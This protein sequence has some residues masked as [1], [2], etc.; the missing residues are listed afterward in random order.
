MALV[1]SASLFFA[2]SHHDT[3]TPAPPNCH[4]QLD[5][6]SRAALTAATRRA[7]GLPRPTYLA[8]LSLPTPL[9]LHARRA[10]PFFL[11]HNPRGRPKSPKGQEATAD[12][13]ADDTSTRAA[14]D[15]NFSTI[16]ESQFTLWV[17]A[18]PGHAEARDSRGNTPLWAAARR[19]NYTL[20]SYL[21]VLRGV[22]VNG[23]T[24]NGST[25]IYHA[26]NEEVLGFLLDRGAE[27]VVWNDKGWLPL[28]H[29][30][31]AGR[32]DCV[33]RLLEDPRGRASI[34]TVVRGED[35]EG[36]SA[37]HLACWHNN[38]TPTA[39]LAI[40]RHLLEAGA[41]PTLPNRHGRN[42]LQVLQERPSVEPLELALIEEAMDGQRAASLIK[43]R[44]VVVGA[45]R[46]EA[47]QCIKRARLGRGEGLPSIELDTE[48]EEGDNFGSLM[49]FLM[50]LQSK[51][52]TSGMPQGVFVG[53]MSMIIPPWHALR[54]GIKGDE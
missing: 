28:M 35:F 29:H 4:A 27:P 6:P 30:V 19:G 33:A 43:A 21:L 16:W 12:M 31:Q 25:A 47:Q 8:S 49:A 44:R 52:G 5:A 22:D 10:S 11:L 37:L 34:D 1:E 20:V 42:S 32:S 17:F 23:Q 46:S 9:P 2:A 48:D 36:F 50:G 14:R 13:A 15:M 24:G 45:G 18:N 54:E 40:L 41:D 3:P 39:K 51:E 26:H 53:M 7:A 38:I